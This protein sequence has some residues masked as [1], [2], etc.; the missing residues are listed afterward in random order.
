M[1][2]SLI[3]VV[4]PVY[5]REDTLVKAISSVVNQTYNKIEIIVIDDASE[6]DIGNIV[7]RN[8]DD[9]RV[10]VFKNNHQVGGA[11]SRNIGVKKSKGSFIAFL[12][13]DD[14][15]KSEKIEKQIDFFKNDEELG[16]VYCDVLK[17]GN[18]TS[19]R[20]LKKGL[21]WD[22]LI[23]GWMEFSNTSTLIVKRK[24]FDQV[25]GFDSTLKSCQDHDLWMK[26]AKRGVKVDY[27]NEVLS[28]T[29]NRDNNRISLDYEN[30]MHGI[31]RFLEKWKNELGSNFSRVKNKYYTVGAFDIFILSIKRFSFVKASKIYFSY[32][33]LNPEFYIQI[34]N[35]VK[36]T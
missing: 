19:T 23:A 29:T 11:E 8:F 21:V 31:K 2:Y 10:K 3:S 30:R 24:V 34:Y 20:S 17:E 33:W 6:Y 32:F 4:I 1:E 36:K 35:K 9:Q 25:G 5:N 22:D 26:I 7:Q 18:L 16:L 27:V 12:D 14:F 13:S 28:F 15:W